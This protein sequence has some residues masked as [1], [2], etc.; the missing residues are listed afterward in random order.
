MVRRDDF[1]DEKERIK[2]I[3]S[4]L[5]DEER[6]RRTNE[7]QERRLQELIEKRKEQEKR[8][9]ELK[10]KCEAAS[11]NKS[12]LDLTKNAK[13]APAKKTKRP[14]D[15]GRRRALGLPLTPFF[16]LERPPPFHLSR[17]IAW[18]FLASAFFTRPTRM[19]NPKNIKQ[20]TNIYYN[21]FSMTWFV[22]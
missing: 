12:D 8:I 4:L 10:K 3:K 19:F 5:E 14:Q 20:K 15:V 18:F 22:W 17:R 9:E 16:F 6:V 2:R 1:Q 21:V 11:Q 7:E 13:W